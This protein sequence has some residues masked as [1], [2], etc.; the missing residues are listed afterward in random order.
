[1]YRLIHKLKKRFSK[2]GGEINPEDIFIDS[3]N[4]PGLNQDRLEGRI[5]RPI[6]EL[7]FVI[8]RTTILIVLVFLSVRLGGLQIAGGDVY[9]KVSEENRLTRGVIFA[10][11]GVI[12]D[13]NGL[14]LAENGIRSEE[15]DFAARIYADIEGLAAVVGYV[16]YPSKDSRGIYYDELYHGQTGVEKTYNAILSGKNGS[17][18]TETDALNNVTSESLINSAVKGQ[19][20]ELSIDALLTQKLFQTISFVAKDRGF[21]GGTGVIMDVRTGEILSLTSYPSY[22]QNLVTEGT[23]KSAITKL[24]TSRGTPFLNR[25]VSGLYT[26]GSIVKPVVAIGALNEKIISPTKTILSTGAL[27]LPNPYDPERPSVFRDWKAH[28]LV[29]IIDALAVSSDVYFYEVGGGFGNQKGLGIS[30]LDQY[31]SLFG[32]SE[33]TGI[34]LP[35]EEESYIATPEWKEKNFPEDPDWRIGN[36]YH[37]AIGQYGTQVTPI[38]ALR[39]TAALANGGK[40]LTPTVVALNSSEKPRGSKDVGL[41]LDLYKIIKEGMRESVLRG[42]A[43]GLS[44]GVVKVAAKTGTAELGA[45]KESVNSWV[46]GFFPYEEPH[47]AFAIVME[48]GP[49]TNTI[50]AVS[51]MRKVLDWMV[52]NTPE[53]LK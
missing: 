21:T 35:A 17:K 14:P 7:T 6:D 44:N 41:S 50:G 23:D 34:D 9:A 46:T 48:R 24:L 22:D 5:E 51:V 16:K 2:K 36:T 53:Y 26:P 19:D 18:L 15:G 37:T 52:E 13:R 38:A 20:I 40:L 42:V 31:F 12:F 45:R 28:G 3:A 49:V 8:F 25:A 39:W 4:L 43:S 1:M 27:T 10:D 11:R 32:M 33:K 29:D 30:K 47:Y